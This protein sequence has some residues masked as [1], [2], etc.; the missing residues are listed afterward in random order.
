MGRIDKGTNKLA[1]KY[2]FAGNVWWNWVQMSAS[3]FSLEALD[4]ARHQHELASSPNPTRPPQT[5]KPVVSGA[6]LRQ[7]VVPHGWGNPAGRMMPGVWTLPPALYSPWKELGV[8]LD[9]G[10]LRSARVSGRVCA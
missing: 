3:N 5:Q 9:A 4:S 1:E 10:P 7:L 2:V 6:A 8:K